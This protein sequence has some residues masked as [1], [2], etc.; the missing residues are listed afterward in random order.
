MIQY[1]TSHKQI[2]IPNMGSVSKVFSEH[3]IILRD[4]RVKIEELK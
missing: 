3:L 4:L 1:A 2:L